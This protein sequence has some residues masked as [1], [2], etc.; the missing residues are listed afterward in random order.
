M[1]LFWNP[2]RSKQNKW[3]G[4]PSEATTKKPKKYQVICIRGKRPGQRLEKRPNCSNVGIFVSNATNVPLLQSFGATLSPLLY[5]SRPGTDV[6]SKPVQQFWHSQPS[7]FKFR[8]I[9]YS[10]TLFF[11]IPST[12]ERIRTKLCCGSDRCRNR[13]FVCTSFCGYEPTR[14]AAARTDGMD[15]SLFNVP[16]KT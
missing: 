9:K 15:E 2:V 12:N 1:F 5:T 14:P 3:H 10:S 4:T 7:C 11:G 8:I 16:F 13:K 6:L